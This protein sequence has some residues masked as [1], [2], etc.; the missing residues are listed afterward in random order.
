MG[1][2]KDLFK[3]LLVIA[4]IWF[5]VFIFLK[6]FSSFQDLTARE[7]LIHSP[8]YMWEVFKSWGT[9]V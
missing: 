1:L 6:F 3:G 8:K 5:A 4:V 2:G 9:T 7:L